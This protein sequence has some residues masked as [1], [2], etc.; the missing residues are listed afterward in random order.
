MVYSGMFLG[1]IAGLALSPT[2]I[3]SLGWP[4]VFYI[5]GSFGLIW[6]TFWSRRAASTPSEDPRISS[7]EQVRGQGR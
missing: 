2:M 7:A 6:Y 5:F 4:S 3:A 1:S